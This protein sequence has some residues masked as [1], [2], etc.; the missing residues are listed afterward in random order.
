[1]TVPKTIKAAVTCGEA[2]KVAVRKISTPQIE[3]HQ[4]L[5]KVEAAAANPT[6]CKSLVHALESPINRVPDHREVHY[7]FSDGGKRSW[8]RLRGNNRGY[9]IKHS[10]ESGEAG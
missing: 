9:W 7:G 1:M 2:R 8:M 6:D 4:V 5:V 10:P 3:P